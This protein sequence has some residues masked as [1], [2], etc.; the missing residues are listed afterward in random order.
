MSAS[1]VRPA[2][3]GDVV[4]VAAIARA[5]PYTA[6]WSASALAAE[7]ARLDA[8]FLVFERD[9]VRGYALARVI[10][11]EC[12]LLDLASVEDGCGHGSAVLVALKLAAK[13]RNCVKISLEVSALNARARAFYM[14]AG[15]IIVGRRKK[16][17][18]DGSDAVLMDLNIL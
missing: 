9:R 4:A 6:K 14:K 1:E 3:I 10:E 13:A 7:V 8:L 5:R 15:A 2:G 12:S 11:R 18:D 17:Y 16:F